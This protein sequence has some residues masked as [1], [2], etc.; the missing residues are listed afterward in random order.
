[1][2]TAS[3]N[4]DKLEVAWFNREEE[5][6]FPEDGMIG[7][8]AAPEYLRLVK[9]EYTKACKIVSILPAEGK[10]PVLVPPSYRNAV[11]LSYAV[12]G[13]A[14]DDLLPEMED[15]QS[16][17]SKWHL[18]P[19]VLHLHSPYVSDERLKQDELVD[20]PSS[21]ERDAIF[22][23]REWER[24]SSRLY[25]SFPKHNILGGGHEPLFFS[26]SLFDASIQRQ[27]QSLPSSAANAAI[28]GRVSDTF[29]FDFND[30][31]CRSL[32]RPLWDGSPDIITR[33]RIASIQ[34]PDAAARSSL[35]AV[36]VVYRVLSGDPDDAWKPYDSSKKDPKM[37][38]HVKEYCGRLKQ[39]RQPLAWGATQ[40]FDD[41][42]TLRQDADVAEIEDDTMALR[43]MTLWRQKTMVSDEARISFLSD[44]M[45][46][47]PKP[48]KEKVL[49]SE[50][51]LQLQ[52]QK[53]P[54]EMKWL[55]PTCKVRPVGE[56]SESGDGSRPASPTTE[57][58]YV[59]VDSMLNS[60]KDDAYPDPFTGAYPNPNPHPNPNPSPGP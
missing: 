51:V 50:V 58:D 46:D 54:I 56:D 6:H 16:D 7:I 3:A 22:S 27:P 40:L 60:E 25:M 11:P 18:H 10:L 32:V 33:S 47:P 41:S 36:L 57:E 9:Q 5:S 43:K 35:F 13:E 48:V 37:A 2:T 39:Y 52:V 49:P 45:A 15:V 19:R 28:N 20:L 17:T 24:N 38:E 34:I 1:M 21:A 44:L 26:L 8:A 31:E 4:L 29:Q 30:M 42:G 23:N 12:D 55:S 59:R 53:R 14:D